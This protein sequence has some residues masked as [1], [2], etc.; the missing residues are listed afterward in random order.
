ME[1]LGY[2]RS[3]PDETIELVVESDEDTEELANLF[4]GSDE[5]EDNDDNVE[6]V[7][8]SQFS[9]GCTIF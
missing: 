9:R 6:L 5:G 7:E 2:G 4:D 8:P 3:N 1:S